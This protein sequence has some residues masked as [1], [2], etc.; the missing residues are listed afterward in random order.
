MK[1]KA[2]LWGRGGGQSGGFETQRAR[3]I[4]E[5]GGREGLFPDRQTHTYTKSIYRY[6]H[7]YT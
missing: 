3:C 4:Y 1:D 5:E 2:T 6:L 7:M